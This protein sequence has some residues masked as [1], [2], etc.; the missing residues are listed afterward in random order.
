MTDDAASR[1]RSRGRELVRISL[2]FFAILVLTE[3]V[4][5]YRTT[6][7]STRLAVAAPATSTAASPPTVR[8]P[9]LALTTT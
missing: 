4:L 7:V 1:S 8:R 5:P 3:L 6:T 2:V 9:T